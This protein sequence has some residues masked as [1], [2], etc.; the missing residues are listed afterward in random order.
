MTFQG[1]ADSN[2]LQIKPRPVSHKRIKIPRPMPQSGRNMQF[3]TAADTGV[4]PKNTH[5]VTDR[6]TYEMVSRVFYSGCARV[7][8]ASS[9][10]S[11]LVTL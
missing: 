9:S 4:D 3:Q 5:H 8:I 10:E 11:V 6:L 2:V 1:F 7:P